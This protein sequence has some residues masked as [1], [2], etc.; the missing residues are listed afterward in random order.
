MKKEYKSPEIDIETFDISSAITTT[1]SFSFEEEE[2][3]NTF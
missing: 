2:D 3:D 1:S